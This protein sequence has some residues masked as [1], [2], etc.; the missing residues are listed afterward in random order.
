MKR[1]P[2]ARGRIKGEAR[3]RRKRRHARGEEEEI[4]MCQEEAEREKG[5]L[6]R[7]GARN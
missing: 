3:G 7:P 1:R 5:S 2:R 4:I 6:L